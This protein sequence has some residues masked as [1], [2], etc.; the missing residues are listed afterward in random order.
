MQF[1]ESAKRPGRQVLSKHTLAFGYQSTSKSF[2]ELKI[3]HSL[4]SWHPISLVSNNSCLFSNENVH[5]YPHCHSLEPSYSNLP[6]DRVT[7]I[8]SFNFSF[9]AAKGGSVLSV[10]S[11]QWDKP[12]FQ[13]CLKGFEGMY[14]KG[15]RFIAVSL[16]LRVV[17][18]VVFLVAS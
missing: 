3:Q 1:V 18:V 6:S 10:T 16:N 2:D 5:G 11:S 15:L 17:L 12:H 14:Y 8:C 13:F 9:V 7:E 4:N